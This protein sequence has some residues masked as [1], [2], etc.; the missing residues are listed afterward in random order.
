MELERK[1]EMRCLRKGKCTI[2]VAKV[3]GLFITGG[4][5]VTRGLGCLV[6]WVQPS[7]AQGGGGELPSSVLTPSCCVLAGNACLLEELTHGR[8]SLLKS[9]TAVKA[10]PSVPVSISLGEKLP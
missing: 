9:S 5:R 10:N 1:E 8:G 6:H 3:S 2:V 4:G 7:R